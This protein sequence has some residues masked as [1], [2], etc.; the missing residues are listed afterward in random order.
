MK[1]Q[2]KVKAAENPKRKGVDGIYLGKRV[3][4]ER[5]TECE[6]GAVFF[7]PTKWITCAL[8]AINKTQ[9]PIYVPLENIIIPPANG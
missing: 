3:I 4:K 6:D 7:V 9:N 5:T 1:N 2:E 8:V